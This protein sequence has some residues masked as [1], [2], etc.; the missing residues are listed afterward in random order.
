MNKS[1]RPLRFAEIH[2]AYKVKK[3]DC[4]MYNVCLDEADRNNW[5]QFGCD[6]C[7]AYQACDV[8]Q[9]VQN[10]LGLRAMQEAADNMEKLGKANRRR[11]VKPGTDAKVGKR[12]HLTVLQGG[13]GPA[14]LEAE[15]V[16]AIA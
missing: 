6:E 9:K 13:L 7:R 2:E 4:Q 12:K 10:V 1:P 5:P 14:P 8:E 15:P 3:D 11:G 16:A